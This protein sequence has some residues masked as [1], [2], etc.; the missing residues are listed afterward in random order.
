MFLLRTAKT[1]PRWHLDA[2]TVSSKSSEDGV[3]HG[4]YGPQIST[5]NCDYQEL[6]KTVKPRM[7]HKR[8]ILF[9]FHPNS[10]SK[11]NTY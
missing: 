9:S 3:L 7:D 6:N 8:S 5:L 4:A 10:K 1:Q 2:D 11:I